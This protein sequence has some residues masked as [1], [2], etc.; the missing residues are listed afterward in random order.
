[1]I[2]TQNFFASQFFWAFS[3]TTFRLA[4]LLLY[5]E[6]FPTV[7]FTY[8]SYASASLV[9]LFFIGSITTTLRLCKPVNFN[10]DKTIQGSCGDEGTAELAAAAINMCLDFCIVLL[11]LPIVWRLQMSTHKKVAVTATFSMG[12]A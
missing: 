4:I 10:W 12:L 11:P 5:I 1:M 3:I 7:W 6:I 9:I 8:A 2:A